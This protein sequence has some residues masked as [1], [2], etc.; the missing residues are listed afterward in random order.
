[1]LIGTPSQTNNYLDTKMHPKTY[2]IR[3]AP[4]RK[5]K[6]RRRRALDKLES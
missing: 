3:A 2:C 5:E 6:T 4:L 1:M